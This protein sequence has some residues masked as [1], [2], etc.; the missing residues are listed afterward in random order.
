MPDSSKDRCRLCGHNTVQRANIR[1][2]GIGG[3]HRS[4]TKFCELCGYRWSGN[5]PAIEAGACP[6]CKSD[7]TA[8]EASVRHNSG[9]HWNAAR[10][11]SAMWYFNNAAPPQFFTNGE[12][13][14]ES[15]LRETR[16]GTF[17]AWAGLILFVLLLLGDFLHSRELMIPFAAFAVGVLLLWLARLPFKHSVAVKAVAWY[18]TSYGA[19]YCRWLATARCFSCDSTFFP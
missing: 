4:E 17:L 16:L 8:M 6:H 13:W 12:A 10:P 11:H 18:K 9:N 5:G 15:T 14:R 3:L 19:D 1:R 2:N 7:D